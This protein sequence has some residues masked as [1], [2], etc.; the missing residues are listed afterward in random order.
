MEKVDWKLDQPN[1]DKYLDLCRRAVEDD[2]VF[3]QFRNMDPMTMIV[4]NSPEKSG[5]EYFDVIFQEYRWLVGHLNAF[6]ASDRIGSPRKMHVGVREISPSTLRYIKTLGDLHHHFGPLS[7]MVIA[8]IGGGYGGLCKIIHDVYAP[9]DYHLFDLPE[10]IALQKK[11]LSKFGITPVT[12]ECPEQIDLLIAMYSWSELSDELQD[13]YLNNVISKAKNCYIML[14]YDIKGSY[15]KL[16]KD[17]P[18]AD[19]KDYHI[20]G[21]ESNTDYAPYD[22]Y[23]IIKN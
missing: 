16:R 22:R 18:N 23:I 14:N 6:C 19:I 2:N 8:E 5:R 15:E 10:P 9:S 12:D 3:A 7:G 20:L 4:E 17:F 13:D 11:F 21:D 1:T